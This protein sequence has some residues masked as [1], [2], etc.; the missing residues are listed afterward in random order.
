MKK[1]ITG[2]TLSLVG[3]IIFLSVFIA[4]GNLATVFNSWNM[5]SGRFFSA[6]SDAKL[7]PVFVISI[8]LI[9]A[10]MIIMLR[11]CMEKPD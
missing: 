5:Q 3:A 4:A 7:Y 9:I 6:V 8:I 10:G 11:G 1:V 2:A